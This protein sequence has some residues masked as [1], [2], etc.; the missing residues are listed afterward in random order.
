MR[1]AHAPL[2]HSSPI[3]EHNAA[4]S[5]GRTIFPS[6]ST[7]AASM[8]LCVFVQ[9]AHRHVSVCVLPVGLRQLYLPI[10][11]IRQTV[12]CQTLLARLSTDESMTRE[13]LTH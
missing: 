8:Q 12:L 11:D 1:A 2:H 9:S 5:R 10:Q 6:A 3:S 13:L 4:G 7:R